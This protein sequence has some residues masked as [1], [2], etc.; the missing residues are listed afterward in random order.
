MSMKKIKR[1][2][3][4]YLSYALMALPNVLLSILMCVC[5]SASVEKVL[6]GIVCYK[7]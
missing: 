6:D 3:Y 2:K 4:I 7:V 5:T 1:L